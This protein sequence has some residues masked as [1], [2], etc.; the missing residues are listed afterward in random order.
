MSTFEREEEVSGKGRRVRRRNESPNHTRVG[1]MWL[2]LIQWVMSLGSQRLLMEMG[3][4]W[5]FGMHMIT[6][7]SALSNHSGCL[8]LRACVSLMETWKCAIIVLL[9]AER[10]LLE[11]AFSRGFAAIVCGLGYLS[12]IK[13]V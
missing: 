6:V 7:G 13:P 4:L 3:T 11:K 9:W 12:S 8:R 1:V 10:C 2:N 5:P